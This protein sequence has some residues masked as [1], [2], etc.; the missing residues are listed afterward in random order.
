MGMSSNEQ[1]LFATPWRGGK[2][3]EFLE[4]LDPR[5]KEVLLAMN[6]PQPSSPTN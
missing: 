6:K 1:L 4:G 2:G 3:Q 5:Q